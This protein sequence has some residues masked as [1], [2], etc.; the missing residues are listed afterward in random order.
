[1]NII[2]VQKCICCFIFF[3]LNSGFEL[4]VIEG[5]RAHEGET[6]TCQQLSCD[7]QQLMSLPLMIKLSAVESNPRIIFSG[8]EKTQISQRTSWKTSHTPRWNLHFKIKT[9]S[10]LAR[11]STKF[12]SINFCEHSWILRKSHWMRTHGVICTPS[13][14]WY[15]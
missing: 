15:C 11:K 10:I 2:I 14:K 1:M 4:S 7:C 5:T 13:L 12:I 8:L 3:E 6:L 9:Q